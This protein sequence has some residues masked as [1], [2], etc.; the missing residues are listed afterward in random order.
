VK[1]FSPSSCFALLLLS[2]ATAA[3]ARA[4]AMPTAVR[5]VQPSA[6]VLVHGVGTGLEARSATSFT[7]AKN[8]AITAGANLGVYPMGRYVLGIEARGTYPL[9]SG[10]LVA[11]RSLLGGIRVTREPGQSRFRPYVDVLFGRGQMDYQR[12]GYIVGNLLYTRTASNLL[13][14]GIGTE[15]DLVGHYSLKVD[16][17]IQ[18][19]N[20]PV[21]T[22]GKVY[23]KQLGIGLAYRFGIGNGPQ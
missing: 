9:E 2:L 7:G 6:F 18:R 5:N 21:T 19:W 10:N 12:G 11:E 8:V 13:D 17:Q 23:S 14:G 20:T 3:N 4:Q 15:V 16:A 22:T 1:I